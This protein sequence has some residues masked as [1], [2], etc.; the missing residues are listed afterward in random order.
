M[1]QLPIPYGAVANDPNTANDIP[2][3]T[4]FQRTQDNFTDLYA[5]QSRIVN[6]GDV[7]FQSQPTTEAKIQAAINQAVVELATAVFVPAFMFGYD[8]T[9]VTF[10]SSIQMVRE[11]GNFSTFDILA[12]GAAA[13]GTDVTPAVNAAV[14][15]AKAAGGGVVFYPPGFWYHLTTPTTLEG[16]TGVIFQGSGRNVT[17]L[18]MGA[19]GVWVFKLANATVRVQI[20]DMWIGTLQ[21]FTTGGGIEAISSGYPSNQIS[22]VIM[23]KV[24]LQ[25]LPYPFWWDNVTQAGMRDVRYLQT[26][27]GATVGDAFYWIRCHSVH[28]EDVILLTTVGSMPRD[29]VRIDSDCDSIFGTRCE[30]VLMGRN[31]ASCGWRVMDSVSGGNNPPRIIRLTDCTGES[32]G[33]GLRVD[34]ARGVHAQGFESALNVTYGAYVTGGKSV[35]LTDG[36]HFLNDQH[37]IYVENVSDGLVDGNTSS[38]NSQVTNNTYDGIVIG[39]LDGCRI[40]NNRSGDVFFTLTN[41]QRAGLNLTAAAAQLWVDNNDLRGNL[42]QGFEQPILNNSTAATNHFGGT[43][44]FPISEAVLVAGKDTECFAVSY[45]E[46]TL[47]AARVVANLNSRFK[48]QRAVFTFIQDGTGGWAITWNAAYKQAWSDTGNTASKRSTIAFVYD[49]T[50]WNQDGAQSPYI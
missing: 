18:V 26:R 7:R 28:L 3:R 39:A 45:I 34:A 27:A 42:G 13:G 20:R 17:H 23:E 1:A 32:A 8:A 43:A 19:N 33:C 48:G 40:T 24:T 44:F 47:T 4:A 16:S 36:Q 12:Y 30:M 5:L 15:G 25:N 6:A 11:G 29:G 38:N 49:G 50:N 22:E 31:A 46:V 35:K 10:N 41:K 14:A 2:I 37:G 9:L 21:N